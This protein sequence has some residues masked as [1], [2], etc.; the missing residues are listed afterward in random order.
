MEKGGYAA[1]LENNSDIAS[2]TLL[3]SGRFQNSGNKLVLDRD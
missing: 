2:Y 1:D 3:F